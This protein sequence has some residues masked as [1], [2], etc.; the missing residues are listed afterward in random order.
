MLGNL[1]WILAGAGYLTKESVVKNVHRDPKERERSR[2]IAESTDRELENQLL[3]DTCDP[4]KYNEIW[5]YLEIYKRDG[6]VFSDGPNWGRVGRYRLEFFNKKGVPTK[7]YE[8]NRELAVRL[9]L[10][11]YGKVPYLVAQFQNR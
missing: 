3:R 6:G 10:E 4:K 9:T 8:G 11:T 1:F 2:R 7:E 5:D